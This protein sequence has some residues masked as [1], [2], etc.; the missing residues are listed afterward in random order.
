MHHFHNQKGLFFDL[1]IFVPSILEILEP[2]RAKQYLQY[3]LKKR[4]LSIVHKIFENMG[5]VTC[6]RPYFCA[7]ALLCVGMKGNRFLSV[8]IGIA[9][10]FQ[11]CI[12]KLLC[13]ILPSGT[14]YPE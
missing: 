12:Q 13:L 10:K 8:L 6:K 5:K 4:M 3:I 14:S 2:L 1:Y 7:T 9:V 11:A